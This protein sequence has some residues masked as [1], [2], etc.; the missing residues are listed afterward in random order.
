MSQ[1]KTRR[2]QDKPDKMSFFAQKKGAALA[3][4]A[5]TAG[6]QDGA[7]H[8]GGSS[9][10]SEADSLHDGEPLTAAFLKRALD[11][12]SRRLVA[13][14]Q[15]SVAELKR[16]LQDIGSRTTH[17]EAKMEDLVD[18]HNAST[19]HLKSL[20]DQIQKCEAKLMDLEDRSRRSNIRLRGIPETVLPADLPSYVHS[21]FKL[22]T[23]EIPTDMLLLDRLHRV[24]KPQHIATSLPRDVLLK[25]HYF[26]VKDLLMRRSRT[27]KDLP[28]E[29]TSIKMFSD[30]SAATL[31]QRKTF[32]QVTETLRANRIL[33]RW[34]FP[35]RLIV[36]RNGTTT[37]V[38]TAE[39][40]IHLLHQW[41]LTIIGDT[42]APKPP[43]QVVKDW[44]IA[45]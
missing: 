41:N 36:S 12:Q 34:G 38:Q 24:P 28:A 1:P 30:L 14:W 9:P 25:A 13:T 35:V 7:D 33:Y 29:Y 15:S 17:V 10:R 42:Q 37:A 11:E 20:T 31:K 21:F 2:H 27:V 22:L 45:D 3:K 39:E 23:P 43:R 26:H 44:H 18:A 5:D 8:S 19:E 6:H 4:Q 32:Q 16:D 40:G